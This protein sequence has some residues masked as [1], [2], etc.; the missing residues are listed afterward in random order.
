[1]RSGRSVSYD[2]GVDGLLEDRAYEQGKKVYSIEDWRDHISTT[3]MFDDDVNEML[4]LDLLSTD[5]KNYEKQLQ[6]SYEL[7]CAGNEADLALSNDADATANMTAEEKK[8]YA[9]YQEKLITQRDAEM[10]KAA[11]GYL[12]S[13]ETVFMAVG[14][15][16]V[17]GEN[18][19]AAQLKAAGYTVEIVQYK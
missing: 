7:W 3:A 15:A 13:G 19:I 16:H 2:C 1:M 6:Y 18:G 10:V 11:K 8:L 4:L 14:H 9:A 12:E 17:I 5:P